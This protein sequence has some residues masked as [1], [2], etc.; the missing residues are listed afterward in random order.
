MQYFHIA[1]ELL[2]I[3]I[4]W[5]VLALMETFPVLMLFFLFFQTGG[6]MG[7]VRRTSAAETPEAAGLPGGIIRRVR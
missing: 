2:F 1:D 5:L 4:A 6:G 3:V 7:G